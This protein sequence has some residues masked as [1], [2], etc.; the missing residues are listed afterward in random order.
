VPFLNFLVVLVLA[1]LIAAAVGMLFGIPSLRIKGL[2][3]AVATLAAQF[4]IDWMFARIK[5]FT[6]DSPS[7][8]VSAPPLQVF[9]YPIESP[10]SKYLF[11]LAFVCVFAL[12]ARNLARGALALLNDKPCALHPRFAPAEKPA[13]VLVARGRC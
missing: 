4:F 1:G 7:G 11:V 5:W 2:Y 13:R 3:L 8:N 9:G 12:V 10:E 6:H